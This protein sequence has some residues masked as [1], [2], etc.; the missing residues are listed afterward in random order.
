[1]KKRS[2]KKTQPARKKQV[3]Q[4]NPPTSMMIRRRALR[5]IQ[6]PAHPLLLFALHARELSAIA[7]ISRVS[8]SDVGELIGYQRPEV[9]A[10]VKNIIDYLKDGGGSALFPN[11]IILALSSS[12]RFTKVRGPQVGDG[13]GEAGT[14][15]IRVPRPGENR[16]AWI[17]DGQQRAMALSRASHPDFAVPIAAFIADDIDTQREQFLR[18]NSTKPL[19]RGLITELLPEVLSTLP[20]KLAARRAPASLCDI[21]NKD[22]QSPFHGLIRRSSDGPKGKN[23]I[24]A[25]TAMITMLQESFSNSSGCLFTYRNLATGETDYAGV[26]KVLMC[27]WQAV[28]DTFPDAWGKPPNQSRLMHGVGLRAMGKLMD[29]IMNSIDLDDP[30]TPAYLR[31]ELARLCPYCAWTSGNWGEELGSMKWNDLQNVPAHLRNLSSHL[32]RLFTFQRRDSREVLPA[33]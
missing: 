25:D 31:K 4:K 10:H 17:V 28:K 7:D 1:M 21:L 20:P 6:D 30:G 16:P 26:L 18:I 27:Y 23:G 24:I 2:F 33:R 12:V 29:R 19:P 14:V 9:R 3:P 8:R 13:L 15:E 5:I 11:S 32:I 22:Q